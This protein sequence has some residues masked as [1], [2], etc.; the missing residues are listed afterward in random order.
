[1]KK[2]L[3]RAGMLAAM[4][5]VASAAT[6]QF[7]P[8]PTAPSGVPPGVTSGVTPVVREKIHDA[9]AETEAQ[10]MPTPGGPPPERR[11]ASVPAGASRPS[12]ADGSSV[13]AIIAALYASVSHG[14]D[15]QPNFDRMRAIFLQVGML[16]PPKDPRSDLFTVLDVDGFEERVRKSIA[17]GKQKGD[18]TSF[19]ESEAAR[20]TD[21]FGNVC[22]VFSTYESRRA[23]SDEK[24]FVRGINSIQL[25]NDGRR[26]WIASVAWD[27]EKP[28]KP[29]PAQYLPNAPSVIPQEYL[30]K[31]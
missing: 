6:A 7:S 16:I 14:E 20:R 12:D 4:F 5:A 15:A 27:T 8:R 1:M 11:A 10:R 30:K 26:W 22:Q 29:I 2:T 9:N 24:P 23:P 18:P 31:N 17:A 25:L 19:F 21:C 13:D 28:E 3:G